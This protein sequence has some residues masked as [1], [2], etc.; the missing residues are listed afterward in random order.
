M[1]EHPQG[2]GITVRHVQ[3]WRWTVAIPRT[4]TMTGHPG[5]GQEQGA[6]TAQPPEAGQPQPKQEVPHPK[7]S[8][9]HRQRDTAQR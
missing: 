9:L 7:T 2:K 8:P 6:T 1:Q 3:P 5:R 4:D